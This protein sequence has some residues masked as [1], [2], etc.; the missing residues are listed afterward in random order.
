MDEEDFFGEFYAYTLSDCLSYMYTSVS[1]DESSSKHS[2]DSDDMNMKIRKNVVIGS[3]MKSENET[4]GTGEC[5]FA[6]T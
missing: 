2:S 4:H 3:D 6:S 5:P 1:E